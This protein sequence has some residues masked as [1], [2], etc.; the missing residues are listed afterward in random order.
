MNC[1]SFFLLLFH[2]HVYS[3]WTVSEQALRLGCNQRQSWTSRLIYSTPLCLRDGTLPSSS[4]S[5]PFRLDEE[6]RGNLLAM[7]LGITVIMGIWSALCQAYEILSINAGNCWGFFTTLNT[8]IAECEPNYSSLVVYMYACA[9][10]SACKMK[11]WEPGVN[12]KLCLV[13]CGKFKSRVC[14]IYRP[15]K[16]WRLAVQYG[17]CSGQFAGCFGVMAF[18]NSS[19]RK[20]KVFTSAYSLTPASGHTVQ[21]DNLDLV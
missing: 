15:L 17:N 7:L 14:C 11:K 20:D 18:W 4:N 12:R 19:Q 6:W 2:F 5:S 13:Y 16:I 8:W 3:C 21:Q 1:N 10:E 9:C